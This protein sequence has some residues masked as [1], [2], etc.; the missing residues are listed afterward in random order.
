MKRRHFLKQAAAGMMLPVLFDGYGARAFGQESAFVQALAKLADVNDRVLVMIQLNGGN[1][2]INMVLP[3]DQMSKYTSL[4]SNIAIPETKAL[5]LYNTLTTGLHPAMTGLQT[6]ANDGKLSIV[7]GV[8]YPSPNFSHFRASD[9]WF[10]GANANQTLTTGWLGRYLNTEYPGY[11][12]KYPS[13]SMPDPLAVQISAIASTALLGPSQSMAIAI[14]NP[15][16][17]AALV[18]DKAVQDPGTGTNTPAGRNLTFIRQQQ[19]SSVQYAAQLK[20]AATKGKNLVT[21]P[22]SN[23]LADQLKI[24][25]R[26][27][28]GG[29][30]TKVYY[31]SLGGFDTHASQ[32]TA[33]DTTTGT[34]A[35]LLKQVSDGIKAFMD[36]LKAQGTEDRVAGMTFS[37][38]GRRVASNGSIGTDHGTAAP[39]FV[40]GK[41]VKTQFI[42]KTPNLS[43]LDNGNLKMQYDFRQI[44]A[45]LLTDWLGETTST[46]TSVLQQSFQ[47]L[48]IFQ[49][50][51][52]GTEDPVAD[53]RLYPNPASSEVFLQSDVLRGEVHTVDVL[54]SAGQWQR[55]PTRRLSADQFQ[56]TVRDLPMGT[57][58]IHV[59]TDQQRISKRLL[60]TR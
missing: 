37:E 28:H 52:L 5:K 13:P 18:G 2:G 32:T 27:I 31:V 21:Y 17:F 7:Q 49:Q 47:L 33:T 59:E 40:F 58:I 39:V 6:L 4:R 29:S 36:D 43:D 48:P 51:Y 14:Q 60:V 22:T 12:D 10:T 54:N 16:T 30:R 45:T 25:A 35:T 15:D 46:V 55:V 20:A 50:L 41:G 42:G 26:L 53:F 34:H 24:V 19:V 38:F 8:S 3:L 23:S 1:D 11:P 44:Y 57:Y 9:I 56:L